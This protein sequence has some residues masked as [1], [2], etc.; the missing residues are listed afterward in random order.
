MKTQN[1]IIVKP[2]GYCGGVLK[3]I[4]TA[5]KTRIQY[6]DQKI[7]ILGNLVHNQYVKKRFN[8][9]PLIPLK[10]RQRHARNY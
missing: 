5:K 7:T 4:E 8:I 9:I 3:A 6:P 2:Q 10:I 1:I